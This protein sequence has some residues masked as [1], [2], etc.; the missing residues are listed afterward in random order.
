MVVQYIHQQ[1]T[2]GPDALV[3]VEL[4]R[5]ANVLLMDAGNYTAFRAGR[6]FNHHGGWAAESPCHL[7]PP[8]HGT[9][10]VVVAPKPGTRVRAGIKVLG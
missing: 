2:G 1:F 9:W 6:R 3:V 7:R 10:H 4:D 5:Q 8:C